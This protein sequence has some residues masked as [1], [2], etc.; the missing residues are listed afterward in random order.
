MAV[1]FPKADGIVPVSSL[2]L[3]SN[4]FFPVHALNTDGIVPVSTLSTANHARIPLHA[5][6]SDGIVLMSALVE[7]LKV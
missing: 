5:L 7:T 4:I 1:Q 3:A 2:S 6:N